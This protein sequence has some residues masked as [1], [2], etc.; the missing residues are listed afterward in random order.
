MSARAP[1]PANGRAAPLW[2]EA[3]LAAATGAP[4]PG[5]AATGVSID[6]RSLAPGDLFVALRGETGDGHAH[7]ADAIARGAAGAMVH[8]TPEDVSPDAPLLRVADTLTGLQGLGAFARARSAARVVAVT[9]SVGKTTTKEMLRTILAVFAPTHAAEAS[10]N[11]QWGVPL[12]LARLPRQAAFAVLE[13]GMNHAGEIAPLAR[14]ARPHVALI[15]AVERAHVGHLGSIAAIADEK[16]EILAGL[17]PGG[18]AVLP[19]DSPLLTRLRARAGTHDVHLF[20]S[21]ADCRARL[22]ACASDADGTTIEA[23]IGNVA[24]RLRLGAP[25]LHMAMNAVAALAAVAALGLDPARAAAALTDFQPLRGRGA[26]RRIDVTGGEALLIDES[27]NASAP[28][29]RAALE[30]LSLQPATRRIVVLGDM[31]EL[32]EEGPGEHISLAP[33]VASVADLLFTCGPL[34]RLLHEAVP[35]R[36]RGAHAA[37]SAALAPMVAA[38]L[39]PGDA[40][41]VKGSLG[42]RM[43]RIV[44]ALHAPPTP[45]EQVR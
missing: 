5:F 8:R 31:L 7:V 11:N 16:A 24:V 6:S 33:S 13:I 17:E 27:Y 34:M 1:L 25:G 12:T 42:S 45:S 35:A 10:Y 39:R 40:V 23:G 29:V 41:L 30:V 26:R 22:L 19:G 4:A 28:A 3:D 36:I 2:T 37:D 21:T 9:G 14:L 32:G 43:I 38:A 20:G 18:I 15:T 44:Q